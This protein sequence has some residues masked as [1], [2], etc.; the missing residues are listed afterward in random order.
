MVLAGKTG[1]HTIKTVRSTMR[2]II[3]LAFFALLSGCGQEGLKMEP[4]EVDSWFIHNEDKIRSIV[5]D[6]RSEPCLRRV[7]LGSMDYIRQHCDLTLE[8]QSKISDVQSKLTDLK[9]VLA[10]SYLAEDGRFNTS[11][12]IN[13]QGIAV[14]GGGLAID[15]WSALGP[16]WQ[17]QVECGELIPLSQKG[18]YA[19]IL[20][21]EPSCASNNSSKKDAVNRASS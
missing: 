3:I 4:H 14:S 2:N 1:T 15:Y 10:T 6:F 9:V 20:H 11:I 5:E 18:W 17:R 19:E 7:E 12:L 21:S 8:L 16:H 13:R